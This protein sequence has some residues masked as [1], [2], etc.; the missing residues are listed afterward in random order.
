MFDAE[1]HPLLFRWQTLVSGLSDLC[2]V[3]VMELLPFLLPLE[4]HSW[5]IGFSCCW[6]CA[7][8]RLAEG[9]WMAP[10]LGVHWGRRFSLSFHIHLRSQ[11]CRSRRPL[12]TKAMKMLTKGKEESAVT[13][14]I[15]GSI[16]SSRA[17]CLKIRSL[18]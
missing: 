17:S 15:R 6:H 11:G 4:K 13:L 16:S 8:S 7:V 5:S 9:R 1:E 3:S 10:W 2:H 12:H 18:R 14:R